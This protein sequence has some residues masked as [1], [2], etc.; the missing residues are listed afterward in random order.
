MEE[1]ST[2]L[3]GNTDCVVVFLQ[4]EALSPA[5][6]YKTLG[7]GHEEIEKEKELVIKYVEQVIAN[8]RART[9]AIILFNSFELPM[10]PVTGMLDYQSESGQSGIV[11][12]LN[13]NIRDILSKTELAW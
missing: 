6:F 7:S 8:I 10:F 5:L 12:R 2:L 4:L 13:S 9:N 3:N 1:N 11:S